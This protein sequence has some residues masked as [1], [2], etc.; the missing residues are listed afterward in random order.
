MKKNQPQA[1]WWRLS[2]AT[3]SLILASLL[4]FVLQPKFHDNKDA[5][6]VLINV[7]AILA[8]FLIAIMALVD[9]RTLQGKNWKEDAY[10]L[11]KAKR[12]LLRHRLM[13]RAY[14]TVLIVGFFV[15]VKP[16]FPII[17]KCLEY[18]ILTLGM[19]ALLMSLR[20]PA[21]LSS[22]QLRSI[23][24]AIAKRKA[25]EQRASLTG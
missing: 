2:F 18:L 5:L 16:D 3:M 17:I 15:Q 25:E 20:L 23:E 1:D 6:A 12:E 13:F 8:G 22:R 10:F 24:E 21:M 9:S 11:E 4:A 7:F 19:W 14:L